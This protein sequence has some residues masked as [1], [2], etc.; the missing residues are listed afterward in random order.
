MSINR[1]MKQQSFTD[2]KMMNLLQT[3]PHSARLNT[4]RTI[5]LRGSKQERRDRVIMEPRCTDS[6][7]KIALRFYRLQRFG[8]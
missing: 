1:A 6:G 2:D 7:G 5:P 4:G 8:C 3:Q